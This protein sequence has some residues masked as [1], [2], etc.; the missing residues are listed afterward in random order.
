MT[1][2][3]RTIA[4]FALAIACRNDSSHADGS[5]TD[6]ASSGD[7][8]GSGSATTPDSDT[9][10][11]GSEAGC[12]CDDGDPCTTDACEGGTCTHTPTLNNACRPTIDVTF[13]P[14]GATIA[15]AAG[16]PTV[17]VTGTVT[18][19]LG[20]ITSLTLGG[21][22]VTVAAD[23][24]F[25]HDVDVQVG[26]NVLVFDTEDDAGNTRHRVQSFLWSTGYRK[27]M[28][29][30]DAPVPEGLGFWLDQESLD[31]GDHSLPVDDLATALE[32]ALGTFD[33]NQFASAETPIASEV[34]YDV[35]L[36][37]LQLGGATVGLQGADG[38]IALDAQLSNITGDLL[39]DC[40]N[41]GCELAGGDGTG[42]LSVAAVRVTGTLILTADTNHQLAATLVNVDAIVNPDDVEIWSNNGWTDFLLTIVEV[43]I[44]DQLV[45][46][47][48]G[49]L[50]EQVQST[51]GPALADGLAALT[52]ATTFEFPNLGN[53][54][55]SIPVDLA[56]DFAST[57]FHDGAA[58]PNDSPPRG[59]A[60]VLR[61]GGYPALAVSEYDNLGVPDR[62]GCGMGPQTLTIPRAAPLEISLAD[63]TLNQLL[64]A[65]WR[66]GLLEFPL[67]GIDGGGLI[68][69][70]QVDVSGMLAPTVS[71]CNAT[72]TL[73]A[74]IGDI[75]IDATFTIGG[76][77]VE[78]Q[79]Y[80]TLV[81]NVELSA[82]EN[83]IVL[84]LTEVERVE[85]ELTTDDANIPMES[86]YVELLEAQLVDGLLGQL[87]DTGFGAISLPQIDLS[88]MLGL[89]PGTAV[90]TIHTD[91][92]TRVDGTSVIVGR[93]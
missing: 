10:D 25:S 83:G 20:A 32:L 80:T 34:G 45:A 42:G 52:L 15:G 43:F 49:A 65:G 16:S 60:V 26:G 33:T 68:E 29:P 1:R 64:F 4:V 75:A 86:N 88:A 19:G 36:T 12:E 21:E 57:S 85:T 24:S 61:A 39:F 62:A 38:G 11:T 67:G 54:R 89:P 74:T 44:H 87:G 92:V 13:P 47:L 81:V 41:F 56:A 66:G 71:D 79:A 63:D 7:S 76:N 77:P 78:F 18:S 84:G 91:S 48:E 2:A 27:P 35:Y 28:T 53:A 59:G 5:G 93:F 73:L 30:P 40:T 23:G 6:S 22:P 17:T 55:K 37:S 46:D 58:P 72:Q 9:A 51:L 69:D 50:E 14:R 82:S 70:L 3:A 8:T 90:L 31:D